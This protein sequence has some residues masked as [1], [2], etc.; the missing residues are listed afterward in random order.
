MAGGIRPFALRQARVE[1]KLNMAG[2]GSLQRW[3]SFLLLGCLLGGCASRETPALVELLAGWPA[4]LPAA[5]TFRRVWQD[6]AD[7]RRMQSE[8]D[9]LQWVQ[10]F[11]QGSQLV[12]GW[13]SV[14]I[15]VGEGLTV[16]EQASIARSLQQLG[17]SI[18]AEWA[19]SN[20]V[21]RIDTRMVAVWRDALLESLRRD[22]LPAYLQI[23]AQDVDALL[24][25]RLAVAAVSY[26]R[27]YTDEFDF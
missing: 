11:Y 25:G 7:N 18:G 1:G 3:F 19:K 22:E 21:R 15:E 9:Y 12:P 20:D 13:L 14:S 4:E 6:D 10:R 17:I 24:A 16:A 26:E 5:S 8:I 2:F 23:L 27:Y